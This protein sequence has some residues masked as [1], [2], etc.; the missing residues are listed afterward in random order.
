MKTSHVI[1]YIPG[2]GDK[3]LGGRRKLLSL[4]HYKNVSIEICPMYWTVDETWQVKLSKLLAR[5]DELHAQGRV[6]SLIGESAGAT[7]VVQAL[8]QRTS[9]LNLVILLCGKS[10]FPERVAAAR[11]RDNP[12]LKNALVA[13][14]QAVARLTP[15]QK[16]M[17]INLHPLFDPVVPVPETKIPEVK[18]IMMPSIGHATSIVFAN[19]LWSWKIVR[20]IKKSANSRTD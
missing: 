9:S 6:V 17:M 3:N 11:Y 10:Q 1:L 16:S 15:S 4:W 13:S 19:T 7:A 2:L 8:E 18:N 12:A 20:C 5:V 14:S